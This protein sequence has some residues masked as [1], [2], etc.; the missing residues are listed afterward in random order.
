MSNGSIRMMLGA[1]RKRRKFPLTEYVRGAPDPLLYLGV[2][3]PFSIP[4]KFST[5]WLLSIW[6]EKW[7]QAETAY[8]RV[9]PLYEQVIESTHP[10]IV[11]CLDQIAFLSTQQERLDEAE[12]LFKQVLQ[13]KEQ[14]L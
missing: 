4:R 12:S 3:Y 14:I 13:A 7:Q 1:M 8:R 2:A 5:N 9:L 6:Q 11:H 10:Y